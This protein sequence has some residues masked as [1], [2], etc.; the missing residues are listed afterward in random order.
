MQFLFCIILVNS[1]LALPLGELS[2]KVTERG[3]AVCR[4]QRQGGK[5]VFLKAKFD[6]FPLS[7]LAALGHLSHGER[8][9]MLA[10]IQ[11]QAQRITAVPVNC[12][13][14]LAHCKRS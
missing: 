8:Q 5:N 13:I 10:M 14:R 4:C 11:E 3:K 1:P 7:V 2:P 12:L 9:G 6:L